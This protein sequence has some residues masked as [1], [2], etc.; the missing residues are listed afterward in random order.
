MIKFCGCTRKT[1]I[2]AQT[3][4]K[5]LH[6]Q[7]KCDDCGRT[8][9]TQERIITKEDLL[10]PLEEFEKN[11]GITETRDDMPKEIL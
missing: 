11:E 3:V 1:L 9:F 5:Y 10:T 2:V 6:K 7:F 4:G 8:S